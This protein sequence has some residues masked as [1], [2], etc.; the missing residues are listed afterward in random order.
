MIKPRIEV[1]FNCK[2]QKAFISQRNMYSPKSDEFLLNHARTG[3]LLALQSLQLPQNAK[4]GMMAYNCHTVMNAIAQANCRPVFIDVDGHLQIDMNDL[5]KK[6]ENLRVLIV[7]HLFGIVNDIKAIQY[8]YPNLIIIEDCAHAYGKEIYGD[9]GVYSIGQGK[10]PSLGDGGI[11][12]VRNKQYLDTIHKIYEELPLYSQTDE[13][14]LFCQLL[15]NSILHK[16]LIYTTISKRLKQ[17]RTP[18]KGR[19]AIVMK[20]MSRGVQSMLASEQDNIPIILN[21]RMEK[22]EKEYSLLK[23]N[24]LVVSVSYGKNA[25][26]VIANCSDKQKLKED[27]KQKGIET[28]THFSNCILWAR[29]FG[30]RDDCPNT[31]KLVNKLLMIPIW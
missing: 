22:A 17:H 28:D 21:Q 6:A 14:K 25:F 18:A 20:K 13:F 15:A 2:K 31:E 11:L 3:L 8:L 1:N 23:N 10:L 12:V 30:Y 9:F 16:P 29:E 24:P 7:T 26:M 19:E 4:V 5:Q 27:Y